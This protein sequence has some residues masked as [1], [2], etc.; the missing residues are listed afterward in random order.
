MRIFAG[1]F[2]IFAFALWILYR[3]FIKQDL[4]KNLAGLYVGLFFTGVWALIYFAML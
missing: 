1:V 4:R 2:L 3:L